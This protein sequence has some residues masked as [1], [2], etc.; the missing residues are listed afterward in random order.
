MYEHMPF[1]RDATNIRPEM[2]SLLHA[3][4][5]YLSSLFP[6]DSIDIYAMPMHKISDNFYIRNIRYFGI[7]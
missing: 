3:I 7:F 4:F 5:L 6:G 1:T 2:N